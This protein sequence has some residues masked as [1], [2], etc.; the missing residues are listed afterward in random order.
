V[1]NKV[2]QAA[3][4]GCAIVTS[5][6]PPQR[7]ALGDAA[8]FVPPGDADA[9]AVTLRHLAIDRADR[10]RLRKAARV[11]AE[12]AFT[13]AAVIGPLRQRLTTTTTPTDL[14]RPR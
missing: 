9:L 2:F 13:P 10:T 12:A 6:T 5:D 4:A 1:P 3:A 7:A 11:R 8:A 14:G